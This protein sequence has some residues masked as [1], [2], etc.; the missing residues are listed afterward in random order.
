[1]TFEILDFLQSSSLFALKN[2]TKLVINIKNKWQPNYSQIIEFSLRV[3]N[4]T[5]DFPD[6]KRH[7][8]PEHLVLDFVN[9]DDDWGGLFRKYLR[10]LRKEVSFKKITFKNFP[11]KLPDQ[12]AFFKIIP[13]KIETLKVSLKSGGLQEEEDYNPLTD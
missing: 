7:D 8:Y 1:M 11:I 9:Q 12:T 6:E 5:I 13:T 2:V 3:L 4:N 10:K